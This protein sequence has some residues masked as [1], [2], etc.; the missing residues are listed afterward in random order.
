[1]TNKPFRSGYVAI[2]GRPN[3]GKST[4]VNALVREKISIVTSKPQTTRHR[5]L[6][7]LTGDDYQVMLVDTPGIHAGS[8]KL[9]NKTMNRAA[10][11]SLTDADL[12]LFMVEATG[13]TKADD[14]VLERLGSARCPCILVPNK[15]DLVK[16]K[17]ALLPFLESCS[18]RHD[19]TDIVPIS[20]AR[21][22]SLDRLLEIVLSSLP[23][24]EML[25][26]ADARTDRNAEFR[27]A[28]VVREKLME[29]LYQEVPYG[30]AVE[31]SQLQNRDDLTLVEVIIWVD[32]ES[33]CGIVVGNGGANLKRIGIAARKDLESIFNNRFHL[34]TRV[35]SRK[36][37]SDNARALQQLGYEIR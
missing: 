29:T 7:I 25:F 14:Y 31:V 5:I 36:N 26:P 3:T 20:A 13:W 30:L 15:V 22:K 9:I 10:V 17:S 21:E 23:K 24:G 27:I 8:R 18:R 2:V 28:E 34:Q 35:K 12:V 16:P 37:W 6:G 32:Q 19:F 1:M 33:H 11:G 4:L